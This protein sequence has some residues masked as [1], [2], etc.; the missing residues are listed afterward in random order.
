[1]RGSPGV[2][3]GCRGRPRGGAPGAAMVGSM[4]HVEVPAR[5][6]PSARP[7]ASTGSRHRLAEHVEPRGAQQAGL[8]C[9][10]LARRPAVLL[11]RLRRGDRRRGRP[12]S[13]RTSNG[14]SSS[15]STR[16]PRRPTAM[17]STLPDST[18]PGVATKHAL[19]ETGKPFIE[20]HFA[21]V[22]APPTAPRGLPVGPWLSTFS[23]HATGVMMGMRDTATRRRSCRWR[24]RSTTRASSGE[25]RRGEGRV[26]ASVARCLRTPP[27]PAKARDF[28][29]RFGYRLRGNGHRSMVVVGNYAI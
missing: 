6:R 7:T 11:S 20:V 19:T 8:W 5:A 26:Q 12:P 13:P 21:N 9:D 17:S 18:V 25:R 24:W 27:E 16:A 1:M 10:R 29:F 15:S 23:P 2:R 14:R 22:V 4:P 28:R 3:P